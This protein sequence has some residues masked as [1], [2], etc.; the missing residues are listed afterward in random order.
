MSYERIERFQ[1]LRAELEQMAPSSSAYKTI[2]NEI[3]SLAEAG[4]LEAAGLV[5][6]VLLFDPQLH[7]AEAAYFF[8]NIASVNDGY[9]SAYRNLSSDPSHYLGEVGDFRNEPQMSEVVD[10]LG[11]DKCKAL[12]EQARLWW[13][14]HRRI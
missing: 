7:D 10:R 6:E 5:A 4:T 11:E 8:F 1:T 3:R 14:R 9:S 12:D 2:F 13:L